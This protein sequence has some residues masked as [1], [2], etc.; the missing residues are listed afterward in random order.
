MCF[1]RPRKQNTNC[2]VYEQKRQIL[3]AET[4]QAAAS[5]PS[6]PLAGK[7]KSA[8]KAGLEPVNSQLADLNSQQAAAART[9]KIRPMAAGKS[10]GADLANENRQASAELDPKMS[11]LAPDPSRRL[12][13]L[14]N[15]GKQAGNETLGALSR[16]TQR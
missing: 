1:A 16:I 3:P 7:G 8:R 10:F 11:P 12:N 5:S 6:C 9:R 14:T 4:N 2:R 15:R 13:Q